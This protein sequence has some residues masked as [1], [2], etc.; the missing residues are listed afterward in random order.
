MIYLS[1][2]N[3]VELYIYIYKHGCRVLFQNKGRPVNGRF[4]TSSLFPLVFFPWLP[5]PHNACPLHMV[6]CMVVYVESLKLL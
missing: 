3:K 5:K 1:N 2:T 4:W 6:T